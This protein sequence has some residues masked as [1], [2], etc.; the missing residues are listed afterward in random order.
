MNSFESGACPPPPAGSF[1]IDIPLAIESVREGALRFR[2][3]LEEHHLP[4]RVIWAC[5][6]ALVESCNNVIEHFH[7]PATSQ[8]ILVQAVIENSRVELR[9]TDHS[10]GFEWPRHTK[11][12]PS[13]EES[14][15]GLYIIETLMDQVNYVRG[16]ASNCLVLKMNV[17]GI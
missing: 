16:T 15:R 11:L 4:S 13:E 10:S 3:F 5:E 9:I 1:E 2:A 6:L 14:G 17:T 8:L 7:G 12:P